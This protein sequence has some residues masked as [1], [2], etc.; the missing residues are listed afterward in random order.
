MEANTA[1][2]VKL[3]GLALQVGDELAISDLGKVYG[4]AA[5]KDNELV[6]TALKEGA[7]GHIVVDE[8]GT[9]DFYFDFNSA[10]SGATSLWVARI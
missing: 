7:D 9:Y 6:G 3:L 8:A 1:S 5:L 4:Y 2:E 10:S